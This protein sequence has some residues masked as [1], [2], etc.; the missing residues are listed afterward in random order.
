MN[1]KKI[2]ELKNGMRAVLQMIASR[3]NALSP[4]LKNMLMQAIEHVTTRIKELRSQGDSV[5][6]LAPQ[7]TPQLDPGPYPSSN[8]NA[9]KYDPNSGKLLVKFHGKDTADSGPIYGYEGVPAFIFDVFKRGAVGPKTSGK[10]K[11]HQWY[12]GVTPSLGAAM[13]ALIKNG[14]YQYQK[15]S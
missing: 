8:I 6:S 2:E 12:K 5:D 11:Y 15:L 4:E 13:N 14:G 3:N 10:N 9:F 7:E 1:E